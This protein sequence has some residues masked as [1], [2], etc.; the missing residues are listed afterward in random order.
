MRSVISGSAMSAFAP[1]AVVPV[2]SVFDP[3]CVKTLRLM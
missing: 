2:K 3:G 1:E